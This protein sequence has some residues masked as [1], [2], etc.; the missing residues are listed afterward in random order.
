MFSKAVGG[1]EDGTDPTD[2]DVITGCIGPDSVDRR[3]LLRKCERINF[4]ADDNG[5]YDGDDLLHDSDEYSVEDAG[6]NE[7]DHGD[8]LVDEKTW[9]L[10]PVLVLIKA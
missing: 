1:E 6:G 9:K 8:K 3:A 7:S 10:L 5:A 4:I 2:D